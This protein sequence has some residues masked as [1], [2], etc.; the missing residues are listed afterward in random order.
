MQILVEN[1][2]KSNIKLG[3]HTPDTWP[4][5]IV[6]VL[7]FFKVG[8][9][10]IKQTEN[11]INDMIAIKRMNAYVPSMVLLIEDPTILP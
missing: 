6:D 7:Y 10:F 1:L 9:S 11:N 5:C 2:E 4:E 8:L 3:I